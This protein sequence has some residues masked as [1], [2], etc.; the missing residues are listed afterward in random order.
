MEQGQ[1]KLQMQTCHNIIL[2]EAFVMC[3]SCYHF[4]AG[5][6]FEQQPA[7]FAQVVG[8][9]VEERRQEVCHGGVLLAA[10]RQPLEQLRT[11][12]KEISLK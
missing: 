5:G 12:P 2:L 1:W 3:V 6:Q 8:R 4:E 7:V 9:E 10:L 11:L